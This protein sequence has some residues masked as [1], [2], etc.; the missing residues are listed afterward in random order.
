MDSTGPR[1]SMDS[2]GPRQQGCRNTRAHLA[3][4]VVNQSWM[5]QLACRRRDV[6]HVCIGPHEHPVDIQRC[7][8]Q[9]F[10]LQRPERL[11]LLLGEAIRPHQQRCS[12]FRIP[13]LSETTSASQQGRH[14]LP[15]L[16]AE[17]MKGTHQDKVDL[18]PLNRLH[19]LGHVRRVDVDKL[20][21]NRR[22]ELRAHDPVQVRFERWSIDSPKRC[23]I[24]ETYN[25]R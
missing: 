22:I 14:M 15:E 25:E 2:T 1:K 17:D 16:Q 19:D 3:W 23:R 20:E 13:R 10:A 4:D 11:D 9:A 8:A 6:E 21:G 18:A 5:P 24:C 7:E 12:P